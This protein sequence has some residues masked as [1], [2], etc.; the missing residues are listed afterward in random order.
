M[1]FK[2]KEASSETAESKKST[3]DTPAL[4]K[5][6]A[7]LNQKY[8]AGAVMR[9]DTTNLPKV[10]YIPSGSLGVDIATGI[11][12]YPRGRIVELMGWES[13]GKTTLTIHAMAECQKAGGVV[14]FIDAEHA[15]DPEYAIS[16]GVDVDKVIFSQP[17][18]GEQALEIAEGL[19]KTKELS[20][21]IIDSV[22]ALVPRSEINGEMGD[23]NMGVHAR[24]MSQAMRKLSPIIGSTNTCVIFINQLREKIGIAFGNPE[25]T[26][27]G[28][29]LKFYASM[30]IKVSRSGQ[31]NK[32][33]ESVAVSSKHKIQIV[34]N[35]MA[36]PFK[37]AEFDIV[38]G[39]GVSKIGEILDVGVAMGVIDKSG[40][41]YSY[42]GTKLGQGKDASIVILEDNPE[43]CEE[44]EEIIKE[45]AGNNKLKK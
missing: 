40:S 45:G 34:K 39:K 31:P 44:I 28:N 41:W 20:L 12:G 15:F 19:I 8:G 42:S 5:M 32:D 26:T 17:D 27:G 1:A 2:K 22:A 37:T 13:S 9:M 30:R 16:L 10:D 35:K 18:S 36:P 4:D 23:S 7:T 14:G 21:L 6:L 29:A 25:T 38:F 11:G 3:G 33:A 24:L 43:M